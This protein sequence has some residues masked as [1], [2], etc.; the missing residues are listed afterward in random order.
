MRY[1]QFHYHWQ[2]NLQAGPDALWP[3][4]AD[5]NRFNRDTGLPAIERRATDGPAQ[6]NVRRLRFTKMGIAVEWEE[7][8]FEW[9]RPQRFGVVRRYLRGPV[10][11][12]RVFVE[13]TPR[14][15]GGTQ[16]VY[17]VWARPKNPLGLAAIPVQIGVLS[18]RSFAAAIRRYDEIAASSQPTRSEGAT[19]RLAPGGQSRLVGMRGRLLDVGAAPALVDRLVGLVERGDELELARIRPYALADVWGASRRAVLELCLLATRAGLL[20]L[21]WELL[22]PLCRGAADRTASLAEIA[23]RL[24]CDTCRIDF[25]VNFDRE[26]EIAFRPN[27]SVRRIEL[28]E[29]CVGGPQVTPHII[30]QQSLAPGA[31][32]ALTLPLETGRYRVR[33]LALAGGQ[34]VE[35]GVDGATEASI[36]AGAD[37]WP[38]ED[39]RLAPTPTL[40]LANATDHPQVLVLERTRWS[41]QAATAA[42]VTALQVFRDLFA[43]EALRPGERISVGSLAVLFTDLRGSTRLYREIGDAPAFGRVLDHFDVLRAAIAAEEGAIVKTIGDAV[44]AVFRRPV[45]AVRAMLKAQQELA[46]PPDGMLPL[47][48]K[49]GIHAGPCIAVTLNDRLDYFGST[50]NIAARLEHLSLG[51]DIVISDAVRCD[52]EVAELLAQADAGVGAEP[53]GA[54]LKGLEGEAFAL[55]RVTPA[56][57]AAAVE[58]PE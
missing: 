58:R 53:F 46:N 42:E 25:T 3:L 26:V 4:V 27:P 2:W 10:A 5:T 9:V 30:A 18:A 35:V 36:S 50:V 1:P 11:E 7:A 57:V 47:T 23:G 14:P 40:H 43:R 20:E 44:M 8:P 38:A 54:T 12:M 29:F 28:S 32:R 55:W 45:G 39:L 41:D 13:L 37:G 48:L 19:A 6:R 24:H 34:Y 52:P 15:E 51:G 31:K 17:R 21:R 33:T 56:V 49:A 22:C 16:L